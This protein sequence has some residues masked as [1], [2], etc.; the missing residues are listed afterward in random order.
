MTLSAKAWDLS[1]RVALV[2]GGAGHV[3]RAVA[4]L[5]RDAG[6]QVVLA[7][8][9]GAPLTAAVEELGA[10]AWSVGASLEIESEV[11]TIVP[12]VLDRCGRLDVIVHAAALVGT[13]GTD[14]WVSSFETQRFDLWRR[15]L[16]VNLTA[17][18]LLTQTAVP[19]LTAAR[20]S[21]IFVSS[22]YGMVGPDL[23]L[24]EGTTMGNP[25]AYAASKGG[26]V[27][28][29]RWLATVLAPHI[30]VNAVTL[31]GIARGQDP[32]FVERYV[33]RTPLGR[34]GSEADAAG[35]VLYLASDLSAWVTGQ[36][37]VV[38]GGWT[39]W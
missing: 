22:I 14:G 2:T 38:D 15:A 21:V 13:S 11:R 25:A 7:D 28:M 17:P 27:Q 36:N 32:R 5:F 19:A 34:M 30:R 29:T 20:G 37:L 9:P 12:Q 33:E 6:A 8:L 10:G 26:L 16:E 39:A 18:V 24:Y 31:G 23:R 35:A 3:G 1:G 4:A